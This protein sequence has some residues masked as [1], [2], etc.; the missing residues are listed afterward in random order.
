MTTRDFSF[1]EQNI[2]WLL[3]LI[4]GDS[5]LRG[6]S[7]WKASQSSRKYWFIALFIV[8]S[9]GLLPLIYLIFIDRKK[10]THEKKA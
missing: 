4:I 10:L 5:I 9:L 7:L 6:Y 2:A 3:P 1:I 8:N